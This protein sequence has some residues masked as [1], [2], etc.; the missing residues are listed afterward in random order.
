MVT[1]VCFKNTFVKSVKRT[2]VRIFRHLSQ[3]YSPE[4]TDK[5]KETN[6]FGGGFLKRVTKRLEE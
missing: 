5:W 2:N 6:L 4:D 3:H 1:N